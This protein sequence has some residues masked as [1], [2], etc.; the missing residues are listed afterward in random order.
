MLIGL[1]NMLKN[2]LPI[3][4]ILSAFRF[5]AYRKMKRALLNGNIR[6]FAKCPLTAKVTLHYFSIIAFGVVPFHRSIGNDL[7]VKISIV[8]RLDFFREVVCVAALECHSVHAL[9]Y[10]FRYAADTGAKHGRAQTFGLDYRQGVVLV[11]FGRYHGKPRFPYNVL[12]VIP[13]TETKKLDIPL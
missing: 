2:T 13:L 10:Q 12:Y 11:P 8:H 9:V 1:G 7:I 6:L 3:K 4:R 5:A